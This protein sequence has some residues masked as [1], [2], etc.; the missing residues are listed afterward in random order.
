M[1]LDENTNHRTSSQKQALP[2]LLVK[3]FGTQTLLDVTDDLYLRD[4]SY[5]RVRSIYEPALAAQSLALKGVALDVGAG[6][7]CFCVPFARA[8]PDWTI[9]AFEPE[10]EAFVKTHDGALLSWQQVADN[11]FP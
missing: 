7:G 2:P 11:S 3:V 8:F 9:W 4:D 1:Q 6:Y 10:A 5:W